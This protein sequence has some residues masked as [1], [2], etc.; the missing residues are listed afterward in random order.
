MANR[1]AVVF[2]LLAVLFSVYFIHLDSPPSIVKESAP[3]TVF[4]APRA[5]KHLVQIA[6]APHSIGTEEHKKVGEYIVGYLRQLGINTEIQNETILRSFGRNVIAANVS[7]IIAT[8]KG[9]NNSKS[10]LLMSHYD[11]QPNAFGAGDDGAGVA[12]MLETARI[13]S[14]GKPLQND[15]I[16]LFT[17]G[18][19]EG[20]LGAAAFVEK[21]PAIKEVG[22]VINVEGRGNAGVSTMFEVNPGNGWMIEQYLKAAKSPSANSLSFEVYKNL[23][24]NTDY[25]LFKNAGIAGLNNAFIEGF[26]NYHSMN[27]TPDHLDQR[28]MQQHGENML[29]LAKHFG[30]IGLTQTKAADI[31]YFNAAAGWVIHYP[32]SWNLWLMISAIILFVFVLISAFRKKMVSVKGLVLGF[33]AFAGLLGVSAALLYYFLKLVRV[34]YPLYNQFYEGNS[35]NAYYYFFAMTALTV[36]VYSILYHWLLKKL[37]WQSLSGG[38]ILAEILM[39]ILLYVATPTAIYIICIPVL[40]LLAGT[41]FIVQK[42]TTHETQPLRYGFVYCI[43]SLPAIMIF[44]PH[45]YSMFVAF[46]LGDLAPAAGILLLLFL[47]LMFPVFAPTLKMKRNIVAISS[48][49]LFV[50]AMVIAHIRSGYTAEYP[51][52]TNV[53]Y[54]LDAEAKKANWIS[55]FS[56]PDFWNKQFFPNKK[57]DNV[58]SW[59]GP[60]MVDDAPVLSLPA[61]TAILKRDTTENNIRKLLVH[62]ASARNAISMWLSISANTTVSEI[63]INGNKVNA[64][65]TGDRKYNS[66]NFVGLNDQGFDIEFETKAGE[67]FEIVLNDRSMGLPAIAEYSG[68]PANVVPGPGSNSNTTQVRK[69]YVF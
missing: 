22:V 29:A 20:L 66:I 49:S 11:S 47:G 38:I 46:G 4:A 59:Y 19:E 65:G 30:N 67:P 40:F 26:V 57:T 52:Q 12:V 27:D 50:I 64:G 9:Q 44:S 3:D 17:D 14:L 35:Y 36:T 62:V 13:L 23:P 7:N 8:I 1:I 41:I 34:A 16:F 60:R 37:S 63:T 42:R 45:L 5:Y 51:L 56:M 32:A 21:H 58:T 18:E 28:S 2:L 15:V 55:D 43:M 54:S 33:L 25:T 31:T 69:K 68:Y 48:F 6:R 61:P 53:F 10:V 24:N 39:L